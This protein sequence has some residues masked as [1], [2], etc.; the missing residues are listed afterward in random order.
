MSFLLCPRGSPLC[1][2]S[3]FL[4]INVWL[5]YENIYYQ[6]WEVY[7]WHFSSFCRVD[8]EKV[9]EGHFIKM[10]TCQSRERLFNLGQSFRNFQITKNLFCQTWT[11]FE[12][13]LWLIAYRCQFLILELIQLY[14]IYI[15]LIQLYLIY[16]RID[17]ALFSLHSS[18]KIQSPTKMRL[19][20]HFFKLTGIP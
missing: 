1:Y 18:T 17:S 6:N 8:C 3:L 9:N 11:I 10:S 2:Q 20:Y 13:L 4:Q 12:K 7:E 15:I 5:N 16:I 14:L 19:I